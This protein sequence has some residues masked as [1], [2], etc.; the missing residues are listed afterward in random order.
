MATFEEQVE[1]FTGLTVGTEPAPD[2]NVFT[3]MLREGV[4]DVVNKMI[5]ARPEEISKFTATSTDSSNS[6]I[7]HTGKI[8]SVVRHH[9]STSIL[10][11]CTPIDPGN[12]YEATDSDSL[13]YRSKIN[14]GYYILNGKIH[15]V[16]A[17]AGSNNDAVVTQISYDAGLIGGDTYGGA[18]IENFPKDYEHLVVLYTAIKTLESAAATK[19]VAQ[20]I[21]LQGSY[22]NL[23]NSLKAEY[24]AAFQGQQQA[25]T[26]ARR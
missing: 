17:S 12:R 14:P 21:E 2:S 25:G 22:S 5:V 16:P 1:G 23:A 10:R 19:T 9:D 11:R 7:V 3:D 26:P 20:D 6:G 8:L 15:T 18:N 4:R 24:N 13:F